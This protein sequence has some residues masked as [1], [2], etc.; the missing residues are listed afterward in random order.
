LDLEGPNGTTTKRKKKR[1]PRMA[2]QMTK[3]KTMIVMKLL[4]LMLLEV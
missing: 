2:R 1:I 4:L 3:A